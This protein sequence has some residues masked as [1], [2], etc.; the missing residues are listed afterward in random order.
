MTQLPKRKQFFYAISLVIVL[1]W[2]F[3]ALFPGESSAQTAGNVVY[4][5]LIQNTGQSEGAPVA[6]LPDTPLPTDQIIIKYNETLFASALDGPASIEWMATLSQI[7]EISLTYFREMSGDAHVLKLPMYLPE[8]EVMRI[9]EKLSK[10]PEVEFAEPDSIMQ[11]VEEPNDP[12]LTDQWHYRLISQTTPSTLGVN[13]PSAWDVTTG[14]PNLVVAVVDTGVLLNHPDLVGRTVPGYDFITNV[15]QANDGNGRDNNPIDPGD[16]VTLTYSTTHPECSRTSDSSWHGTHVAGTIGAASDNNIGVAGVN[17][18]SPILPIRVLGRCGGNTSDI[19]DGI[20]WAAGVAVA[21]VPAN[22]NPARIINLSL[23]GPGVC[24]STYQNAISAALAQN[25]VVVVAAG[26]ININASGYRPANC[27]GV[28]TV[29]ATARNGNRSVWNLAANSASNFGNVV[30]ISAPGTSILSTSNTGQTIAQTHSYSLYNG[31]SMATPHV[32]GVASLVLSVR[33]NLTP[34]QVLQVLTDGVTRFPSGGTCTT[35]NCGAGIVNADNAV[36][37]LYVRKGYIGT[38]QG[39]RDQP[40]D[41]ITEAKN[42]AWDGARLRIRAGT[43][44]EPQTFTFD[45]PMIL[46]ADRGVVTIQ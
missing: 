30:E 44:N 42:I 28:I 15:D 5:P 32:A 10:L 4:L 12:R 22:A 7:A 26:N 24:G 16:W 17:W 46:T 2:A 23:G 8:A 27:N 11:I 14:D 33:P 41:T 3:F 18:Q 40:Y 39:F 36:R 1:L 6:P 34:A 45:Q 19:A 29:A 43:Y 35:T 25:A 38:E 9:A 20:R 13:L 37:D 31:T 21:G